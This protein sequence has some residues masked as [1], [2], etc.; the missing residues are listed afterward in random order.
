M[1]DIKIELF[2][3]K[4]CG[5]CNNFKPEWEKLKSQIGGYV[6]LKEYD[7]DDESDKQ[8]MARQNIE[9][10]PTILITG[11][12]QINKNYDEERTADAIIRYLKNNCNF[13]SNPS[14]MYGGGDMYYQKY[15]KY[16]QKYLNLKSRR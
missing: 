9:G 2:K 7:A 13:N 11:G 14:T 8:Y 10:F 3:A 4:W 15:R 12:G 6:T 1:S 5:H 16:K